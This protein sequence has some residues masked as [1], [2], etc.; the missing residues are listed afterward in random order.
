M[1][2]ELTSRLSRLAI[3]PAICRLRLPFASCPSNT[4]KAWSPN[5]LLYFAVLLH[6]QSVNVLLFSV[7]EFVKVASA[8]SGK[9]GVSV[10]NDVRPTLKP[11][12]ERTT[13]CGVRARSPKM[14]P[15]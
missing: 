12:L 14:F 15:K 13:S 6:V 8:F 7:N 9:D 1:N 3:D 5:L 2:R 4:A 11:R 10:E